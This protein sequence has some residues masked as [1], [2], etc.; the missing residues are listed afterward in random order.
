MALQPVIRENEIAKAW[1]IDPSRLGAWELAMR[2]L[3]LVVS[4]DNASESLALDLLEHAMELSPRDPLPAALAA[5]C[6]GLRAGH[7]F[8]PDSGDEKSA[9]RVLAERGTQQARAM[10]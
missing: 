7:N 4:M 9:A 2:A 5:W 6:R 3:R 1:Q 8:C 10:R